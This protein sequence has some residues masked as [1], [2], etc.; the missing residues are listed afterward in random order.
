MTGLF[1]AFAGIAVLIVAFYALG[2]SGMATARA[3]WAGLAISAAAHGVV[4]AAGVDLLGR[5]KPVRLTLLEPDVAEARLV[6]SH[7]QE[8]VAIYLWLMTGAGGAPRAYVLPWSQDM[9]E[10]LRAA[11]A[12]AEANGTDVI[13]SDPFNANLAPGDRFTTPPPPALP[14]KRAE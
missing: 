2:L 9:A 6:A 8:G 4:Y 13:V 3:R 10:A 1:A 7:A 14:P 11:E 12:E 5:A